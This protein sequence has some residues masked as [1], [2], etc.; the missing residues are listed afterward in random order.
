MVFTSANCSPLGGGRVYYLYCEDFAS[1]R[2][3]MTRTLVHKWYYA[4]RNLAAWKTTTAQDNTLQFR[5]R[6]HHAVWSRI[7]CRFLEW[8]LFVLN[9]LYCVLLGSDRSSCHI[10]SPFGT[11]ALSAMVLIKLLCGS[12]VIKKSCDSSWWFSK[13]KT[14]LEFHQGDSWFQ[15]FRWSYG[16]WSLSLFER[17]L[18]FVL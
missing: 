16:E 6:C 15:N 7:C 17:S 3:L 13:L 14:F 8:S 5:V 2:Q 10:Y 9:L 4:G 12:W 11:V 18:V 1:E